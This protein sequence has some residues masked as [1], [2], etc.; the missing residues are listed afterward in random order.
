MYKEIILPHILQVYYI[1]NHEIYKDSVQNTKVRQ[2]SPVVRN[3]N[4]ETQILKNVSEQMTFID[5]YT[6]TP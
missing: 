5:V 4:M 6:S 3:S 1:Q 2:T